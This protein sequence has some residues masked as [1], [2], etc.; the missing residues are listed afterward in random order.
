MERTSL[1]LPAPAILRALPNTLSLMRLGAALSLPFLP[2]DWWLA[3]VLFAGI[4]DWLDGVLARK[5]RASSWFGGL[6]DGF[7][8]KAFVVSAL[9]T[10]AG[11]GLVEWWQ[12]PPL[13]VRDACVAAGVVLSALRRDADAFRNMDSRPFGKLTTA[14]IFVLLAALL[15]L[16]LE[17][18]LHAALY[19]FGVVVGALAGIDYARARFARVS[20]RA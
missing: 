12:V 8:D 2:R 6:L 17:R 16:P 7:T 15:L 5:F 11:A 14:L 1:P 3:L 13:L 9:V 18:A 19:A 4:S 20:G 10:F